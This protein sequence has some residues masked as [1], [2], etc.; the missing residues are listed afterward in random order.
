MPKNPDILVREAEIKAVELKIK[1]YV[2]KLKRLIEEL[3]KE[4]KQ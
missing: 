4:K 1:G 2:F 3:E